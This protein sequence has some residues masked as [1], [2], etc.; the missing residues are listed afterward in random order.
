MP[1][2]DLI[3]WRKQRQAERTAG[4]PTREEFGD[5]FRE[6]FEDFFRP[7]ALTPRFGR[8][9]AV[10]PAVD[11][12][13]TDTDYHVSVELPGMSK[14]EV[15]VTIDQGRLTISGE[16]KEEH[17]EERANLLRVERSYGSFTRTIPLPSSVNEEAVEAEFK[18]GLLT[19]K[20]PKTE[21]ARGKKVEIKGA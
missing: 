11:V 14:D 2:R 19:I 7:W 6:M 12:S 1:I 4:L 17:K 13:E 21:E 8:L 15:Q 3:P 5:L 9:F 20:L 10:R 16:K 18:D